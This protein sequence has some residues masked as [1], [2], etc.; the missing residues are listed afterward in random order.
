[1]QEG[2][3]SFEQKEK[4]T[5]RLNGILREYPNDISILKEIIQNADDAEFSNIH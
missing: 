4:L 2:F 3:E 1:M 5:S